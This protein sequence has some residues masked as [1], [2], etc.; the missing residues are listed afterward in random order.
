MTQ[1][2]DVEDKYAK[3]FLNPSMHAKVTVMT[4]MCVPK[5]SLCDN[6]K[7]QNVSVTLTVAVGT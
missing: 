1:S 5:N 7:L 4:Q 2:R 6:G 3:L